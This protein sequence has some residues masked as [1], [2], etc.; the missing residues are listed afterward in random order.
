[1]NKMLHDLFLFFK[2]SCPVAGYNDNDRSYRL[3]TVVYNAV[4]RHTLQKNL[5]E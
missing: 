2:N 1:M 3:L 4:S 5:V